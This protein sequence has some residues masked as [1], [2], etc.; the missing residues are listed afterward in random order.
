MYRTK[1]NSIC[2]AC[3]SNGI[4]VVRGIGVCIKV[5]YIECQE[6]ETKPSGLPRRLMVENE[7]S[8]C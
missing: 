8:Q 4:S 1:V 3:M 5:V 2:M 6:A 7:R